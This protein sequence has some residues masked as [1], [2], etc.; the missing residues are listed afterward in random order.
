MKRCPYCAE[1][2]QD[3]AVKC[4]HCGEL[5]N[6]R[7][8]DTLDGA[9]TLRSADADSG[10]QYDTLD[11]AA[12]TGGE[13]TVLAGQYRIIKKIGEGGM[14]VVYLAEDMEMHDRPVAIKVLPPLLSRNR[15]AVENLR[16]EAVIA[17]SLNHPNII[18][19]HGFHSDGDIKFLVMEYIDGIT[20]EEKIFDSESR[21]LSSDETI[22]IAEKVSVALDYAH[23]RRSPVFHRD[24]KPSNIMISKNGE[25]K[26]L[27]FGIAREMKDSFT[28]VTGKETSGTLPYMSPEQLMGEK[29]NASMDIYSLGAVI[30]ECF[31][32]HSP[33]YT[34][35]L[36]EQIKHKKPDD[37]YGVDA[38]I[39]SSLQKALAKKWEGRPK[40]AGALTDSLKQRTEPKP[41]LLPVIKEKPNPKAS[42]IKPEPAKKRFKSKKDLWIAL[43]IIVI[44]VISFFALFN[45]QTVKTDPVTPAKRGGAIVIPMH[46]S[47]G[48]VLEARFGM[49]FVYIPAGDFL[50]GSPPTEKNRNSDVV[51]QHNV[52]ISKGFWMGQTEVTQAQYKAVMGTNPSHFKGDN[53]PV[54][55]VSWD[56]AT[57]FCRKLSQKEG[58]TYRLPTEAEWEYACRAGT[59][60]P[61]NTGQTISTDQANYDGDY[62]YG[63][64]RKG[65]DRG[66]TTEVGSFSPN[67]FGLYDMHGNVY[68]WCQDWYDEDYYSNS[69][70]VDPQGPNTGEYRVLRGGS[71]YNYPRGCRS[72]NR[73]RLTPDG[74]N[75]GSGFRVVVLDF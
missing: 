13:A 27:D 73:Y 51:P 41:Q 75:D 57:E 65:T 54:E 1:E 58:N 9:A 55:N 29:P 15:R 44:A 24:L 42:E 46:P 72:A 70:S 7:S 4:K 23:S 16:S 6:S 2:I 14:G 19:L 30:Y 18:R 40:T 26:L 17:I 47:K 11:A 36:R 53:N 52:K 43:I 12:T 3:D 59:T 22:K 61:F 31:A 68:E 50:M 10:P 63:N 67:A 34:G 48:D 74:T 35:D 60:T 37:I 62:V 5:L 69:P 39:N 45:Q 49:N 8:T 21:K 20:L 38:H 66:K 64:G 56:N 25:I 28:R 32:G 33:F 71:W